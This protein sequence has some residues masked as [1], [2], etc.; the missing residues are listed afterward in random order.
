MFTYPI[1]L[2]KDKDTGTYIASCR[3]LPLMNS[4]GDNV[5]DALLEAIYGLVTAVSI[6][7][8]ERRAIPLGSEL[9]EGEYAVSLPVLVAM[10]ASLHN[11]MIES[12][13]RKADLARKMGK[14]PQQIDRLLDAE[15]SSKVEAIEQALHLLN[16]TVSVNVN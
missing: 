10:K 9:K 14:N 2:E 15:H 6:E 4:V 5:Q 7:I 16:K 12:G 1:K 11:A 8:D 3:D 13:T